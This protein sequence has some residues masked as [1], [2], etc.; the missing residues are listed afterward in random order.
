MDFV[1]ERTRL[2][3]ASP[4]RN[5]IQAESGLFTVSQLHGATFGEVRRVP[6]PLCS[7]DATSRGIEQTPESCPGAVNTIEACAE[8]LLA[9][10]CPPRT[11]KTYLVASMFRRKGLLS[12]G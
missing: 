5:P 11:K 7:G 8:Q 10:S 6:L 4:P 1:V 2:E 3:Q 12:L 9:S